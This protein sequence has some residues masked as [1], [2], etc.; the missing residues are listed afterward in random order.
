MT[1][2]IDKILNHLAAL[3]AID[4]T[5]PPREIAA[6]G[7]LVEY[8]CKQLP[9]F[10]IEIIDNTDGHISI[11]A[12]RSRADI[13]FNVHLDTVPVTTGW[14]SDPFVLQLRD[15]RAYG[16]GSCD[17]KAAAAVL[18]TL[19]AATT[20]PMALLFTTDE[21]G[22]GGC[23]IRN[24]LQSGKADKFKQVVVAEPTMMQAIVS[25]RG[26]LSVFCDFL[27]QGGHSST[28]S[29]LAGSAIHR[30]GAWLTRALLIAGSARS[31]E[32]DP[33]V[34][35][36]VGRV[37]GGKKNN[38]IAEKVSLSWSARV[39]PGTSSEDLNEQMQAAAEGLP[40]SWRVSMIAP[41]LPAAGQS[42]EQA[43]TFVANQNLELGK[44]VDFWTEAS[45][46]SAHGLPALVL[47]PGDIAQAHT[48]DE[49][50]SLQQLEECYNTYLGII[51]YVN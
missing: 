36:N 40:V 43:Q 39:P 48:V 15:E 5:N 26:Y 18:L 22:A 46:F 14:Q 45:L 27:G 25:H 49:W 35:F 32:N 10:T 29:A 30:M 31:G 12:C 24:F 34:C 51:N 3:V 8:I 41:P 37:E 28:A 1:D 47:G 7:E 17:I 4:T 9:D 21:E 50:V 11:F 23:C 19:A 16:R 33:G 13:L 2:T 44:P 38:M 20:A 42:D 6:D